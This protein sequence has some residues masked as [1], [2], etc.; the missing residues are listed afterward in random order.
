MPN[1]KARKV[2]QQARSSDDG[3]STALGNL[4]MNMLAPRAAGNDQTRSTQRDIVAEF[5][6]YFGNESNLANWQEFCQD[7]GV[8]VELR[9]IRQCR[10]VNMRS[11]HVGAKLTLE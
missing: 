11:L 9:S 3:I 8:E 4:S 7:L 5:A 6:E 2:K 1:R 10:L